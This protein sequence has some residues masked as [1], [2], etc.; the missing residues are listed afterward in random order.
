MAHYFAD[1]HWES[2]EFLEKPYMRVPKEIGCAFAASAVASPL[3]AIMDKAM[4]KPITGIGA[5]LGSMGEAGKEMM[6]KPK[7]FFGGLPFRL[8]FLVYFGTYAAANVSEAALDYF[9]ER[10]E[11]N[12]KKVK[13]AA[14]SAANISLLQWRDSIF[15]REYSGAAGSSVKKVPLRTMTLF[16]VRDAFTMSATFYGAPKAAAYLIKE[17]DMNHSA[18]ELSTALVI[19]VIAQFVTAPLHIH[20]MHFFNNP[21]SSFSETTSQI[22]AEYSKVAFGRGLRILPA[23]GLGSFCN[24]K[25]RELTIRQPNEDLLLTRKVTKLIARV[26]RPPPRRA[27]PRDSTN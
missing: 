10:Q 13:V 7:T 21:L 8:T 23:F 22:K 16:G 5:L 12:R 20:A 24:N 17:H 9:N 25:F 19:P 6:V 27:V 1:A 2:H 18:A 3:V 11:E 15:A 14:A 26:T 4:V